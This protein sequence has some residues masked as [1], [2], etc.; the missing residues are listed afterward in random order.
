MID[1]HSHILPGLDDGAEDVEQSIELA[2]A[3]VA[4]G[5]R[6]IAGT[7]HVRDDFPT[8]AEEM[9]RA[10]AEVRAAVARAGIPIEVLPGGEIAFERL[11]DL[12]ADE[13]SRFGLGGNPG[14]LLVETPYSG[15]PL[16]IEQSFHRL[17]VADITPVLAHPERNPEVQDDV[18]P[19][20]RLARSGTLVQVTAA[21]LAGKGSSSARATALRL[22]SEGAVHLVA[23]DAHDAR[24]RGAGLASVRNTV[25]SAALAHWLTDQV[26]SA[27]VTGTPLP[28][29]PAE[30]PR[31]RLPWQRARHF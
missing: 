7:P 31:R 1:L 9:E 23:T 21:S 6:A 29:R 13:L 27:I 8:S 17:L 10:L 22:L 2:R 15:W 20:L 25:G 3:A 12:S 30:A 4:G 24:A 19:V 28:P 16:G 14:Y 11:A 5:V 18:S 26:P